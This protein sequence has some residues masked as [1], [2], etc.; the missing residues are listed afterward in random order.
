M[1]TNLTT[2]KCILFSAPSGAGKTTIVRHLLAQNPL[3]AFSI[4][5]CSRAPRGVEEDGKDYYFLGLEK[6]QQKIKEEAFLEWEEVYDDNYYGTLKEEVERIWSLG[7]TVVFDV[8]VVG[9]LNIKK[10]L[11][12]RALAIFVQAPSYEELERRLRS[13]STES[14]EK[15]QMRMAKAK[16]EMAKAESF[17]VILENIDLS[18]ACQKAK[19]LVA[20]FLH[21]Q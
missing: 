9:A 15:I 5:A 2:G 14:E 8:D 20:Q 1:T 19:Q 4:S 11:G 3:L 6:F 16:E 17:D 13:R 7:K 10:Q 18:N 21:N 12:D